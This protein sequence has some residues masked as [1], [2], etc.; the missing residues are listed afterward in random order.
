MTNQSIGDYI[1]GLKEYKV[2]APFVVCHKELPG[3][4]AEFAEPELPLSEPVLHL[5]ERLG[6]KG[7]YAHQV[8]AIDQVRQG[9]HTVVATP[10]ASGKTLIYNIIVS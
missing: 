10:T 5:L 4:E 8:Q 3:K 7:L 9:R 6:I 2:L 1:K